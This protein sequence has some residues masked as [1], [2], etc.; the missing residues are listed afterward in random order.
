MYIKLTAIYCDLLRFVECSEGESS[1]PDPHPPPASFFASALL[2][3]YPPLF[4]QHPPHQKPQTYNTTTTESIQFGHDDELKLG[5]ISQFLSPEN[6]L[7]NENSLTSVLTCRSN[8]DFPH[9]S[10]PPYPPCPHK[11]SK[12]GQSFPGHGFLLHPITWSIEA[13]P[14]CNTYSDELKMSVSVPLI[15]HREEISEV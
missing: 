9:Q 5:N 13:G 2:S 12:A 6:S 11:I 14:S 10:Y 7:F 1:V 3:M 15:F 8:P 4:P